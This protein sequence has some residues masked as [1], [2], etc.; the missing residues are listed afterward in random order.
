MIVSLGG[1]SAQTFPN[2]PVRIISPGPGLDTDFKARL[3]IAWDE[4]NEKTKD[5]P[6]AATAYSI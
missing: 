5:H 1:A 4:F 3:V 2:K 6:W